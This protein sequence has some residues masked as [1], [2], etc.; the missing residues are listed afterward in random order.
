MKLNHPKTKK[1]L[2]ILID[3]G[4]NKNIISPNIIESVKTVPNTQI[5]NV[6]GVN[7]VTSK[8]ELDLFGNTFKPLQFYVMK[9]HYFFDGILGSESLAKLKAQINYENETIT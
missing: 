8:G 6:C 7:N 3:T 9:F 4:A 2:K 1:Q 5:S